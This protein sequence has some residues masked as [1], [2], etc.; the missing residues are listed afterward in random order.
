MYYIFV[1]VSM[2]LNIVCTAVSGDRY[3]ELLR[4]ELTAGD[5]SGEVHLQVKVQSAAGVK[6]H[7]VQSYL[8]QGPAHRLLQL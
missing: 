8:P 6:P 2:F 5:Q 4:D 7:T 3:T 1:N